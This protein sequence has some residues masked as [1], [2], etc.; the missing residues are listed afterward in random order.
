MIKRVAVVGATGSLGSI[1]ATTVDESDHFELS[2]RI[3]S[4]DPLADA[5]DADIMV[6]VTTP[7]ASPSIVDFA[8]GNRIPIIVGTSGW[9]AERIAYLSARLGDDQHAPVLIVPNFAIGAVLS[10]VF[11]EAAAPYF[12]SAEVIETHHW[13]KVD[14][15]SGTAIRAAERIAGAR[16]PGSEP[17]PHTDQRARGQ[18]VAGVPVHSVRMRGVLAKQDAIFGR[19]GERLTISHEALSYDAYR[20]GILLAL[21]GVT[22]VR[23]VVVGLDKL[24]G[25]GGGHAAT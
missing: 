9:T 6:E 13:G 11:A 7:S 5:L 25:F 4:R 22:E 2:A 23:G 24:M 18:V 10:T 12:D 3:S 1:V 19:D 21:E 14:S 17:A 15:P 16:A 8:V 20:H